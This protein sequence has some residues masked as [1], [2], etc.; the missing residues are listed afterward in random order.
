MTVA[1]KYIVKYRDYDGAPWKDWVDVQGESIT[2]ASKTA[3]VEKAFSK[4]GFGNFYVY[5]RVEV[6]KPYI[7]IKE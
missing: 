2:D 3:L 4:F 7:D 5:E 6:V 1:K